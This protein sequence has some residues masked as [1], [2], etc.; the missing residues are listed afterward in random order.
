MQFFKSADT[1][2]AYKTMGEK[3]AD[4][5]VIIWAHGWGQSHECFAPLVSPL[6]RSGYHIILDLPGFGH[7][8][9]PS[10]A[11]GTKDYADAI[12]KWI[13][14]QDFNTVIW[15]G[16]SF[17]CRVG[18]QLAANHPCVLDG[19]CLISGAGLKR[20]RAWHQKIYFY[21]RIRLFKL[22]RHILPQGHIKDKIMAAFGSADYKS[23]GVMRKVFVR[24]VNE[25]LSDV[26]TKV[27]CPTHLI[28]GTQDTETPAEF[29]ERFSRLIK[30]SNLH[31]LD[32]Q[33][34]YSVLQNGRHPVIKIINDFIGTICT[35]K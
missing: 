24:V 1:K 33:D 32:G 9:A 4:R 19:L 8:P 12:A 3:S 20:K 13:V 31:L 15:V 35:K 25:D 7:S 18:L 11:W 30:D 28:Y 34:H 17:G 27:T 16:H 29:G 6:M 22:M 21:L 10:D 5:P 23:A 26:A 14:Q 2:I